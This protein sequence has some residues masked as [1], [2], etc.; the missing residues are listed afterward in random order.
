MLEVIFRPQAAQD[1]LLL[2]ATTKAEW[3]ERQARKYVD[4]I[5]Q[6]IDFAAEFPGIGSA[7]YGLP[8]EYRKLSS[9]SHRIIYRVTKSQLIVVRIIHMREDVPDNIEDL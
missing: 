6:K 7:A 8:F 3:G 5:R 9:G 1:L 2:T 4:Q